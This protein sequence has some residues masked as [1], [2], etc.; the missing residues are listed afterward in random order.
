MRTPLLFLAGFVLAAGLA[1][2]AEAIACCFQAAENAPIILNA[3]HIDGEP[4]D[5]PDEEE[6]LEYDLSAGWEGIELTVYDEEGYY[7][8]GE[9]FSGR[10]R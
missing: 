9:T 5:L 2:A 6:G 4:A 8:A 7:V 1:H 3:V 10:V